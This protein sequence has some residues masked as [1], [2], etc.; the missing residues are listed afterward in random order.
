[1]SLPILDGHEPELETLGSCLHHLIK[2]A[3]IPSTEPIQLQEPQIVRRF[4]PDSLGYVWAA[5]ANILRK[6][7]PSP[8]TTGTDRPH[9]E[10]RPR[11]SFDEFTSSNSFQIEDSSPLGSSPS[12]GGGGSDGSSVGFIH[13]TSA[14]PVEDATVRLASCFIRCVLNYGQLGDEESCVHFRDERQTYDYPAT[15]RNKVVEATDDGGLQLSDGGNT[16]QVALLE[17]K[18]GFG[19]RVEGRPVVSDEVLGQLV[20]EALALKQS[21]P[22]P[23]VSDD[24]CVFLNAGGDSEC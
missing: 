3:G 15:Q 11:G 14:P 1:M 9:R 12:G 2:G 19:T 21:E 10:R 6:D 18:R 5:L 17:A 16:L 24:K 8:M 22:Y 7:R 13:A 4:E 23:K 20:G